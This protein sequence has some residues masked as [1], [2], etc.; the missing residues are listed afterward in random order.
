MGRGL[1][2]TKAKKLVGGGTMLIVNQ[3]IPRA[4]KRLGYS[5]E[6]ST[7]IVDHINEHKTVIG[8]PHF[9]LAHLPVF[10]CS[11]GDN[12]IHYMG[13]VKMMGAVQPFISGAI[14]KTA[15]VPENTTVEVMEHLYLD[16]RKLGVKAVA[17]YHD[18]CKVGRPLTW[19]TN[20]SRG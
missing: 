8:A 6:Q 15:N 1:A 19:Q 14:S 20:A 16:A 10:A 5:A 12:T 11:M 9:D 2:L 13:H 17:L 3:T 18:N 4:L 7:A